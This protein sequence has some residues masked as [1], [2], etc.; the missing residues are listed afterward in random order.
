MFDFIRSH[1][2]LM[3]LFI[4]ILIVPSFVFF[5]IQGYTASSERDNALAT[6]DGAPITQQEYDTALRERVE[7]LRQNLGGNFD[8]KLLETPE[9]RAAVLDQLIVDRALA[10]E[11]AQSNVVVTVD[12]LREVIAAIP[13]F[14]Q[15]GKFSYDRYKSFLASRGQSEAQFEESLRNDLRKQA[16]VQAV[17]ESAIV[18]KQVTD[19]IE[20]ILLQQR[21]VRQLRFPAQ[22][23]ASKVKLTDAQIAEYYQA[24]RTQ[25]E[26]PENVRIEYVVL[27][28]DTIAGTVNISEDAARNYYDQNK[29]RYGTE[30][31]RRASHIL[32]TAEGSDKDAARKKAEAILAKVKT[33]PKEFSTLAR[34]ASQD[35][36]SAAQG[37]DLGFFGRGMMVKPFEETVYRLKEG[38]T[39]ELVQTDFGFHIIRVTEI[40]PAQAKPFAEVRADI[41]RELKSQQAQKNFTEAAD[42]FTNLV[43]EQAD[44]LQPAAAKL[45]LKTLTA[46]NLTR[47]GLPPHI[48]P[49]MVEAIFA[50]DSLKNKRNTQATE[51]ASNTLVSA[52]V[53]DYRPA[54]VQPLEKVTAQIR[55]LLE[56]REAVRLAREA[57]EQRL[58]ALRK[59]PNNTG[60]SAPIVVSRRQ[61]QDLAADVLTEV[62][63]TSADKLPQFVGTEVGADF[64]QGS[65]PGYVIVQVLSA[66]PGDA[67]PPPQR[68]AQTRAI[69]QQAAAAAEFAYAE[70]LKARH[71]VKILRPELQQKVTDPAVEKNNAADVKSK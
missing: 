9:A 19:R 66:K 20:Q 22:E 5:G 52:R 55:Q 69:T 68:E 38:E 42:Q 4:L 53:L 10:N 47:G 65:E 57:G 46:D 26:T 64:R 37:G 61:P 62:L 41:E 48:T 40:K 50:E 2:S 14:Q 54:A 1:R 33:N 18:P 39:S 31:Q 43:Y 27:S 30:E 63:R 29:P 58:A 8:P 21:E 15:D 17:V 56:Q 25:F 71:N 59:E 7:R 70:G 44:S 16:F 67:I 35:P 24:N 32:I 45:N 23:F 12:R 36:G 13:A 28:P 11:A 34:E 3:M 49:R 6:V 60:F 51:V